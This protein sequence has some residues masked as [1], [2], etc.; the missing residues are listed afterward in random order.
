M[1]DLSMR[2]L[3]YYAQETLASIEKA[4]LIF[5]VASIPVVN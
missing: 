3:G 5:S 4:G 1:G 2:D